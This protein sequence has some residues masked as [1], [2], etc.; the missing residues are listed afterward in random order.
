M[1]L[2]KSQLIA[3]KIILRSSYGLIRDVQNA[4]RKD[5]GAF[6]QRLQ[7]VLLLLEDELAFIEVEVRK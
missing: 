1:P 3:M 2:S 7:V 6:A 4:A 5:D